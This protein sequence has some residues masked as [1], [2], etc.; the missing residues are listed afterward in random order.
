MRTDHGAKSASCQTKDVEE[1]PLPWSK[2][3][4]EIERTF[5]ML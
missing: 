2:M 5:E 1:F 4:L 3:V